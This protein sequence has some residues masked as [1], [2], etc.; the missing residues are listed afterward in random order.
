MTEEVEGVG[1][2]LYLILHLKQFKISNTFLPSYPKQLLFGKHKV[3]I[4]HFQLFGWG[5]TESI[6]RTGSEFEES[7]EATILQNKESIGT[8]KTDAWKYC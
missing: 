1:H 3:T 5:F 7:L 4:S 2:H 8:T 6:H